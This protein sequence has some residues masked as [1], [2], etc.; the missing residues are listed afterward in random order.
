ML[1]A[2][3]V[4]TEDCNHC[5]HRIIT[6]I[7]ELKNYSE[8]MITGGEPML[9]PEKVLEFTRQLN[10]MGFGY[11]RDL[12]LYTARYH[13]YLEYIL[14]NISGLHF[15]LHNEAKDDDV[16]ELKLMSRLIK[17]HPLI[18]SR[19]A[20]DSRLYDR[21]DFSNIDLTGWHV[22]RK[23]KW[24]VECPLPAGEELLIYKL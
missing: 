8:V 16:Y 12:Y 23:L 2:R 6:D 3:V 7:K 24:Q 4:V 20:I 17:N 18:S 21:Y 10:K 1:K 11:G 5:N 14:R 19:L 9:I 15:T 13:H 22:V